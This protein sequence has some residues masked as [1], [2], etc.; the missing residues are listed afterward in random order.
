MI[1]SFLFGGAGILL[2]LWGL[3]VSVGKWWPLFFAAVGLAS[4]ARGLNEMAHVVFGLLLLGWSTAGIVSLHGGE[5]GIPHSLPFFLGAFILWI[6]LSWL[7][8][9]ILS[10]DTR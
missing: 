5:L 4:F 7:I 1:F 3:G 6:P 8:G 9:R 10:T 2:L